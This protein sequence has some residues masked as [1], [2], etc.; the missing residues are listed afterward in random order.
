MQ[1]EGDSQVSG[2][3]DRVAVGPSPREGPQELHL[4][5][6][7]GESSFPEGINVQTWNLTGLDWNPDSI[8]YWLWKRKSFNT[9]ESQFY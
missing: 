5:E 9:S 7:L 8:I 6:A 2:L 3:R 1:A 4:R